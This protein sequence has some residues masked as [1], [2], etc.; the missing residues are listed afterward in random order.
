MTV[1]SEILVSIAGV[2]L[3]LLF[4]YIPGLRVWFGALVSEKKQLIMLAALIIVTGG[5]FGLGCAGV[6]DIGIPCDKG[7]VISIIRLLILALIANQSTYL[8]SP[9][10]NDVVIAKQLRDDGEGAG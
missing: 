4:S 1:T 2:V 9:E 5:V 6:L 3:S 7:G 10:T 8:I